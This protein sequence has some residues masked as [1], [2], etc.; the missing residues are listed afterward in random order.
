MF[1]FERFILIGWK[2]LHWV[3]DLNCV[4]V[5]PWFFVLNL[6][7]CPKPWFLILNLGSLF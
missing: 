4:L 5:Q 7:L 3:L 2:V 6:V 1:D